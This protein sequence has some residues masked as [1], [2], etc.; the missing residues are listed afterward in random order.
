MILHGFEAAT[1]ANV[2]GIATAVQSRVVRM[3]D[4]LEAL[5]DVYYDKQHLERLRQM[6]TMKPQVTLEFD[7][8]PEVVVSWR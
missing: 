2:N 6:E 1:G 3:L 4:P 7:D 5:A 8:A